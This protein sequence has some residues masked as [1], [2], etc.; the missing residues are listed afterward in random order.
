MLHNPVLLT[1]DIDTFSEIVRARGFDE[2]IKPRDYNRI[3]GR[4]RLFHEIIAA[5]LKALSKT[6]PQ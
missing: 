4:I 3:G 2:D 5:G 1:E 6:T